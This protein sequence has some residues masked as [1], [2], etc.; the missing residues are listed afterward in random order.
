MPPDAPVTSTVCMMLP[1]RTPNALFVPSHFLRRTGCHP[2]SGPGQAFAK[3][4][5]NESRLAE[6][7]RKL[8]IAAAAVEQVPAHGG[9]RLRHRTASDRLHDLPV[10]LL[11]RLAIDL[12]RHPR[13]PANGLARNDQAAQMLQKAS[14]L[15]VAG[16]IGDAA[17]KR[18]V[19]VDR[20]LAALDRDQARR[21][22]D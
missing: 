21:E 7:H 15:R 22:R 3:K 5:A 19:L 16:G 6:L 8:L 11:E 4:C 9:T 13:A 17:V 10:F 14:E 18:E 1:P 12:S 2:V 20:V